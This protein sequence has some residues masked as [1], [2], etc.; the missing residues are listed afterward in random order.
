[1]TRKHLILPTL[2]LM[3]CLAL[4][5]QP[6]S[7]AQTIPPNNAYLPLVL[8]S[9][10]TATPTATATAT[11]TATATATKTPLII[12]PAT[13]VPTRTP[14]ATSPAQTY[15]CD[16]DFY[17]CSDFATQPEAQAVYKYCRDVAH[18]GD[19][20]GL[21]TDHDGIACESLPPG[22]KVLR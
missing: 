5:A 7:Q 6:A 13:Q 19:V 3:A 17:N 8:R 20:H 18:A 10:P 1:M 16:H 14:T 9:D 15:V 11:P 12:P 2:L 21:D 22:F 4:F